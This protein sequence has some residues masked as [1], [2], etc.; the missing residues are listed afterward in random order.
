MEL[1]RRIRME[2][3]EHAWNFEENYEEYHKNRKKKQLE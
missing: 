1:Q 3:A 2:D